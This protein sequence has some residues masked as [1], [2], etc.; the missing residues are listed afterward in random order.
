MFNE[1]LD[2]SSNSLREGLFTSIPAVV[3]NVHSGKQLRYDVQPTIKQD[4]QSD[5]A[6]IYHVPAVMPKSSTGGLSF[7]IGVGDSVLLVFSQ[8]GLETWKGSSS[9]GMNRRPNG[10]LLNIKDAII[11]PCLFPFSLSPNNSNSN[12]N[13]TVV[14]CRGSEVRIEKSTGNV[15]V[16]TTND[17]VI[18]AAN[19]VTVNS[20]NYI[21]NAESMFSKNV[22]ISGDLEVGGDISVG[23][24]LTV[25]GEVDVGSVVKAVAFIQK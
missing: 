17:V 10:S 6:A 25:G 1:L 12:P 9:I 19:N 13:D 20:S 24:N 16:N 8:R 11:I 18:N 7:E 5:Y 3:I 14:N 4:D 15:I 22:N 2:A 21:N 23:G